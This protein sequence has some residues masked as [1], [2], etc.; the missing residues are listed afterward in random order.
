MEN[1]ETSKHNRPE[2][3]SQDKAAKGLKKDELG[4]AK[5]PGILRRAPLQN[6]KARRS[7]G[8]LPH[9]A[10]IDNDL[11]DGSGQGLEE[12][13]TCFRVSRN[14]I[15]QQKAFKSVMFCGTTLQ[16]A[17]VPT[18]RTPRMAK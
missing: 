9:Y 12:T 16:G 15:A 3:S 18:L 1:T 14:L 4:I 10:F 6:M 7:A 2:R 8:A 5:R 13:R 17:W 11:L